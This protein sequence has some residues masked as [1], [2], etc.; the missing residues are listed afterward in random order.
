MD[1]SLLINGTESQYFCHDKM[2]E[3][4]ISLEDVFSIVLFSVFL[5]ARKAVSSVI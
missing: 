3:V 1:L 2:I 5:L 4:N